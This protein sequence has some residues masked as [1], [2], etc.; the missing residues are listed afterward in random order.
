[1]FPEIKTKPADPVGIP[2]PPTYTEDPTIPPAYNATCV[3]S[4][5]FREDNRTEFARSIRQ[6]KSWPTVRQDP[7]FSVFDGMIT[8]RF[9]GN[10]F[11]YP[12]YKMSD[13]PPPSSKIK[14][15]PRYQIDRS[16]LSSNV[17][18]K[19]ESTDEDMAGRYN[20]SVDHYSP[21]RR[22]D[23][24]SSTNDLAFNRNSDLRKRPFSVSEHGN[25]HNRLSKRTR[26]SE[27]R[28]DSSGETP[29]STTI[30]PE[31]DAWSPQAC[32]SILAPVKDL[33]Q[34]TPRYRGNIRERCPLDGDRKSNSSSHSDRRSRSPLRLHEFR[35][36]SNDYGRRNE[37]SLTELDLELLGMIEGPDD[38]P[39]PQKPAAKKPMKRVKVP[40]AY[41]YGH[42]FCFASGFH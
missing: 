40:E 26:L 4:E 5:Y 12:S 9:P 16:I 31:R 30:K 14:L 27:G 41:A 1:V 34:M 6:H 13:T 18:A 20:R 25:Q 24:R 28:S 36:G 15:P 3:K 39:V 10:E 42:S 7:A 37:S 17:T 38:E 8:R 32:E 35:T 29:S 11:D 2:L 22:R 23:S 33:E 21:E 19:K